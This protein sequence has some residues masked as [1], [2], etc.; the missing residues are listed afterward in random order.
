MSSQEELRAGQDMD[1]V[2]HG[3]R[4]HLY[5]EIMSQPSTNCSLTPI[6]CL[7]LGLT[8][9]VSQSLLPVVAPPCGIVLTIVWHL[10]SVAGV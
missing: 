10:E 7:V 3:Q 2:T 4:D 6:H 9:L 1:A 5:L 8:P